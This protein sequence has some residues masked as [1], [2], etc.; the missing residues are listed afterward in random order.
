MQS[1]IIIPIPK[2]PVIDQCFGYAKHALAIE[3][4]WLGIEPRTEPYYYGRLKLYMLRVFHYTTVTFIF[5]K[6]F[7]S[8][9]ILKELNLQQK[10]FGQNTCNSWGLNP[11]SD[12]S[13][14]ITICGKVNQYTIVACVIRNLTL[15]QTHSHVMHI[16][17]CICKKKILTSSY[18]NSRGSNP[19]LAN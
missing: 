13:M 17:V 4:Q 1:L 7:P 15:V 19:G 12:H 6:L 10:G 16:S 5:R 14:D 2:L 18:C 9:I 3:L 8:S 11:D